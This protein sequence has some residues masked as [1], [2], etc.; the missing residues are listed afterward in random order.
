MSH[1]RYLP[2]SEDMTGQASLVLDGLSLR[3]MC[4]CWYLVIPSFRKTDSSY[5]ILI[6]WLTDNYFKTGTGRS[7][8]IGLPSLAYRRYRGD[9]IE[10]YKYVHGMY[11]LPDSLLWSPYVTGQTIIFLWSP[12]VIGQT[13]IFLPCDF[14][15]L[16]FSSFFFSFLA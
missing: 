3:L 13:T 6:Y 11:S 8:G 1:I 14:Y 15:L 10:V 16:L 9:M 2:S 7:T 12:Y 5:W 4:I